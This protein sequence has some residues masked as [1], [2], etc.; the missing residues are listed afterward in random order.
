MDPGSTCGPS[1]VGCVGSYLAARDSQGAIGAHRQ[2][3]QL[4]WGVGSKQ[5]AMQF[6]LGSIVRLCDTPRGTR[7]FLRVSLPWPSLS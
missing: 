5:R 7:Q 4:L 2:F 6:R 3:L 1:A